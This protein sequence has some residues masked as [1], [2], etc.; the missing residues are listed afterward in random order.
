[1]EGKSRHDLSMIRSSSRGLDPA[2]AVIDKVIIEE[3][4]ITDFTD[5]LWV[6]SMK[7]VGDK[8]MINVLKV[9]IV[10]MRI[11]HVLQAFAELFTAY[12]VELPL[13]EVNFSFQRK[14]VVW[15]WSS[16]DL[17]GD[18]GGGGVEVTNDNGRL[19]DELHEDAP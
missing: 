1:M 2:L 10:D 13:P 12:A 4:E 16:D 5:L 14:L 17:G 7:V 19:V 8:N 18:G 9:P 11:G 3:L 6:F 15:V